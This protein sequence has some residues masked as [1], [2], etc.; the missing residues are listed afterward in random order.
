MKKVKSLLLSALLIVSLVFPTMPIMTVGASGSAPDDYNDVVWSKTFDSASKMD[1]TNFGKEDRLAFSMTKEGQKDYATFSYTPDGTWSGL[2]Y[3]RV[4]G[5]NTSNPVQASGKTVEELSKMRVS[6]DFIPMNNNVI[7]HIPFRD[8]YSTISELTDY[9]IKFDTDG[10]IKFMNGGDVVYSYTPGTL[11]SF[12]MFF[13]F[14]GETGKY[15]VY[16]NGE[17][18]ATDLPTENLKKCVE[19][20][21][22]QTTAT[23]DTPAVSFKINNITFAT[24]DPLVLK[25]ITP[26]EGAAD[27]SLNPEVNA[28]FNYPVA[29]VDED[30]ITVTGGST[31]PAYTVST[32]GNTVKIA[33]TEKLELKEEYTVAF[34]TGA[35]TAEDGMSLKEVVTT[36]FETTAQDLNSGYDSIVMAHTFEDL[37]P[38]KI[39]SSTTYTMKT[40]TEMTV[41]EISGR[42]NVMQFYGGT[43]RT[44]GFGIERYVDSKDTWNY[45]YGTNKLKIDLELKRNTVVTTG[46]KENWGDAVYLWASSTPSGSNSGLLMLWKPTGDSAGDYGKINFYSNGTA[47]VLS[48][49]AI[50]NDTWCRITLYFDCAE[51]KYDAYLNGKYMGQYDAPS[52][53]L[54]RLYITGGKTTVSVDNISITTLP[55]FT[56]PVI[57]KYTDKSG[58]SKLGFFA[59]NTTATEMTYKIFCAKYNSNDTLADLTISDGSVAASKR[60]LEELTYP[61][62]ASDGSYYKYFIFDSMSNI[63]PLV[64]S[65]TIE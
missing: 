45:P 27:V 7:L 28:Q 53:S 46:G 5:G 40:I 59:K 8:K 2:V 58:N 37:T 57:S 52:S 29:S 43:G 24:K 23:T 55:A 54:D 35:V 65:I 16:I 47:G 62:L 13:D 22:V 25:S 12:D 48:E 3:M 32:S 9:L 14:T 21:A 6:F 56:S 41:A 60:E 30:K 19:S 49:D 38:G 44:N 10:N 1:Y 39:T 20:I 61:T 34:A 11:Y 63:V 26:A 15:S 18:V 31:T 42:G 51:R 17:E 64:E 36:T 50:A 33:F 4:R